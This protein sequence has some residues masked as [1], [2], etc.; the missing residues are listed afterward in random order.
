MHKILFTIYCITIASTINA[1][2]TLFRQKKLSKF[3][4]NSGQY[5]GIC[6][7]N[8]STYLVVSDKDST[9]AWHRFNI[10][11]DLQKGKIKDISVISQ[12]CSESVKGRDIEGIAFNPNNNN[13]YVSGEGDQE[14]LEYN[15]N[16]EKTG[17]KLAVPTMY[18]IQNIRSNKG[19]ESL[20]YDTHKH[21]F[22]TATEAPI[23]T[24]KPNI[25]R[26]LEFNDSLQYINQI[27]Y[28]LDS[29]T[30]PDKYK[31]FVH[32]ISDIATIDNKLIVMERTVCVKRKYLGS[33]T[34]TKLYIIS[35]EEY[36]NLSK[37]KTISKTLLCSFTTKLN[38]GKMNIANYE[39]VCEGPTLTDGRRTLILI[40]DSQDGAGNSLYKLKDYIKII[41]ID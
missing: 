14:V 35:P 41:V 15:L 28:Q 25:I 31:F 11:W 5:S 26:I 2:T 33:Y 16:G 24:D 7:V 6:K 40:N 12:P 10:K 23:K 32:G 17:R 4:I 19:F 21:K 18:G 34:T 1:Q 29:V 30:I 8:D 9:I 37:N 39:G 27:P 20:C 22:W 3:G 13:V 38:V 36:S